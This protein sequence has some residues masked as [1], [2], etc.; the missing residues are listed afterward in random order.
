MQTIKPV[1]VPTDLQTRE[2]DERI[3]R[4]PA[5]Q[6]DLRALSEYELWFVGGGDDVPHF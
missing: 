2:T 5:A 6:P 3:A 4:K 1:A